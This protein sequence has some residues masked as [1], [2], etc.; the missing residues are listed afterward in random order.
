MPFLSMRDIHNSDKSITF[1]GFQNK[2]LMKVA[3]FLLN[4]E[5]T[6]DHMY[7]WFADNSAIKP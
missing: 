6:I 2:Y 5:L 4:K 3:S 7:Y 1:N